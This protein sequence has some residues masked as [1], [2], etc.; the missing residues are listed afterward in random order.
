MQ[1]VAPKEAVV[2]RAGKYLGA[3][4]SWKMLDL[5]SVS[6]KTRSEALRVLTQQDP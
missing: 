1:P 4:F 3:S 2:M 5:S 6:Q